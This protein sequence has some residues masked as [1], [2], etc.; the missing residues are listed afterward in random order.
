LADDSEPVTMRELQQSASRVLGVDIPVRP[1]T[2][3]GPHALRRIS[4]QN[5]RQA[6]RYRAG[7]VLLLGDSAHVHSAMGG[8]G[9]NL[10]LQDAMNLGWKLAATVAGRAP[11]GLLDTYQSE[12]HPAGRRVM[13]QSMSQ[14]ALFSPGP[15]IGALRELFAE[16]TRIPAVAAHIGGLLAGSDIRY[17]VGDDHPL[18]GYLVPDFT[19]GDGRRIADLLHLGR[20]VLVGMDVDHPLVDVVPTEIVDGPAALLLRPDGYVAWA[21]DDRLKTGLTQ[22]VA[23]WFSPAS[24]GGTP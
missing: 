9:L 22:A 11:A 15:E 21:A 20:P 12:R 2:G 8:P 23:R 3:A 7:S 13:M 1:P 4:G 17:D 18:S 14:T 10:G 19:L 24:R 5:T 6:D 16:L